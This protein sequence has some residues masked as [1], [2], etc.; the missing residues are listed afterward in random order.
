MARSGKT[1]RNQG[2]APEAARA[3]PKRER[4]TPLKASSS[5]RDEAGRR[6]GDPKRSGDPGARK[7]R[8]AGDKVH[9]FISYAHA[10]RVV[11][12]ALREALTDIDRNRVDCFLDYESIQSGEGWKQRLEA[13][14]A[15]IYGWYERVE[16]MLTAVLRDADAVPVVK[17]IQERGRLA[18]LSAVEDGLAPGWGARGKPAAR[19]R[20]TPDPTAQR[21]VSPV[22]AVRRSDAPVVVA[23][24]L[25]LGAMLL[26]ILT[27][28]LG[29]LAVGLMR[30]GR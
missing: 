20:A 9:V 4:A 25:V 14:L 27:L 30:L 15:A 2:A 29:S 17:E 8:A 23:T 24:L 18:Y 11:A 28:V 10:D 22:R 7:A 16:P 6:G 13:A 21:S 1:V 3:A 19:L 5:R 12:A 26:P